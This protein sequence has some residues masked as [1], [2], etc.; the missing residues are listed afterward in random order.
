MD[1][2]RTV[3]SG[4]GLGVLIALAGCDAFVRARVK[5]LSIQADPLPDA[6]LRRDGAKE[7]DLARFTDAHGCAYFS[8]VVG[9]ATHVRVAVGKPGYQSQFLELGAVHEDC[10]VV[11]LARHG[12]SGGSVKMLSPDACP[13]DSNAGY[14]PTMAARFK[15]STPDG[16][17]VELVAVRQLGRPDYPWAQVTDAQGCLG[18]HWIVSADLQSIPLVLEK[19]GYQP[20]RVDVPTMLDRCYAVSLSA[21]VDGPPSTAVS[22]AN[23]QCDCKMFAGKTVWPEK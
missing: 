20:A 22:L 15:V 11:R 23:D 9:P 21:G 12:E 5:V 8:G 4:F 14:S 17:P 16:S 19:A 2:R 1:L 13:C 7:H 6:L 3:R 10:F 18:V